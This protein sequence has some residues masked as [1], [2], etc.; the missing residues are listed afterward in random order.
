M[1]ISCLRI[2]ALHNVSY[3]D[4]TYTAALPV[5]WSF[6]EP[7]IGISV[8]S[9]PLLRPLFKGQVFGSLFTSRKSTKPSRK[10]DGD[11]SFQRLDEEHALSR[12]EPKVTISAGRTTQGSLSDES[13]ESLAN[14][15][16]EITVR[17]DLRMSRT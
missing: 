5:L 13:I 6:S 7:A 8:A 4:V 3:A 12:L 11:S 1:V 16:T 2:Y 17:H 9:A 15:I 14:D 10:Q